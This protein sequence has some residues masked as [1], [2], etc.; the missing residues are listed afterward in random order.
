[1]VW[2]LSIAFLCFSDF[3]ISCKLVVDST[4]LVECRCIG[5]ELWLLPSEGSWGPDCCSPFRPLHASP[6]LHP[7]SGCGKPPSGP[8]ALHICPPPPP[9]DVWLELG[10]LFGDSL[11]CFVA[12]F[13]T[14]ACGFIYGFWI[15]DDVERHVNNSYYRK[16]EY[17]HI[18]A[19]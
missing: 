14:V 10:L 11:V 16:S 3:N 17:M 19:Q 13:C 18:H 7:L 2:I 5:R 9:A 1:M 12:S 6:T 15:S 4:E 8:D